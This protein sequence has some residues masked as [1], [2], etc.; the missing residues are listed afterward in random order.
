MHG[1]RSIAL[2][3]QA[4]AVEHLPVSD[5]DG[6]FGVGTAFGGMLQNA[7][8]LGM[9]VERIGREKFIVDDDEITGLIDGRILIRAEGGERELVLSV[10]ETMDFEALEDFGG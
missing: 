3:A 4:L 8:L 2:C 7:A 9:K 6:E 1:P 5:V 10:L